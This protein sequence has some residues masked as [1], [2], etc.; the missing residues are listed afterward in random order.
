MY[1]V[2]LMPDT[3]SREDNTLDD[4]VD[5]DEVRLRIDTSEIP[6]D[7][8]DQ[9]TTAEDKLGEDEAILDETLLDLCVKPTSEESKVINYHYFNFF[10]EDG[11]VLS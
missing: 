7:S 4:T 6:R 11:G 1:H 9:R 10:K 3:P 8:T 5:D 2:K